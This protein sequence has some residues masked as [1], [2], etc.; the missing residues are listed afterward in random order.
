[1]RIE[2]RASD[3]IQANHLLGVNIIG[4]LPEPRNSEHELFEY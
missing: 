1:M 2:L 3:E 4:Q